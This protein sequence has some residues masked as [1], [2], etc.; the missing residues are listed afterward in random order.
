LFFLSKI[1]EDLAMHTEDQHPIRVMRI[2]SRMN[3][4]GPAVQVSGLMREFDHEKFD[5]RLYT[6]FCADNEADYLHTLAEDFGPIYVDGL[7]RDVNVLGDLRAFKFLIREIQTF[8]PH[9]IH[10]HTSK[11]GLL[12]R[13]ASI[14]SGHSSL[15][16]HT[17][18][19]HL[20][21]GYFGQFKTFLL[22][23]VERVLALFTHK[24][25]S[26]GEKVMHDLI[27]NGIGTL[28]K[29]TVMAPG[30]KINK[31]SNADEAKTYLKLQPS[32]V[33][34]AFIGRITGIKRPDRFLDVVTEMKRRDINLEFIM[35]GNGDLFDACQE[36]IKR[37]ELP[38][39]LLGW[40]SNIELVLSATGI[41][42]LTSDNEGMPLSLIQA[43]MSSLPVIATN[44]GSV[45][46]VVIDGVT[47]ILTSMETIE[48]ADALEL[49]WREP[50]IRSRLGEEAF[51]FTSK[52]FGVDRLVKDHTNL[53]LTMIDGARS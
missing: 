45:S 27:T 49:L 2:I 48:I 34:C 15:R 11:A 39:K 25:L 13:I 4:G 28:E 33:Y 24:L 32:K 26:V 47:G 6:G 18:H 21:N 30:T 52:N 38:V 37:C 51:T 41:V 17:Y 44:V 10:T 3:V 9:I 53:Y 31:L 22:T 42:I 43:G 36:R 29:F 16:I 14:V 19:G 7:G 40:Q 35:V 1:R 20:L 12:G 5:Q 50:K 8:K 23:T 46:E